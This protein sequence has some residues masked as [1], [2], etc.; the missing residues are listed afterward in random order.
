PAAAE[1]GRQGGPGDSRGA[2]DQPPGR[3][4]PPAPAQGRRA[5]RR[6]R[7]RHPADLPAARRG[8]ARGAGVA[9]GLRGASR[10]ADPAPGRGHGG[11][12]RP[13]PGGP[14]P[15]GGA[16]PEPLRMAFDVACPAEHAFTVWTS[17]IGTWW[18]A[19]HTVSGAPSA[20]V[21]EG[22]VGGRI[23]E[24]AADGTEHD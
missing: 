4:P 15:A 19:D 5:G 13:R 16:M 8:P 6:A 23:Y 11:A 2:A 12:G 17:A 24:R 10:G 3:V 20:V 21:M 22:G 14:W 9:R 7:S 1:R 18:P